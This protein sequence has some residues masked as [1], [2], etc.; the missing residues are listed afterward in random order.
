MISAWATGK[1]LSGI[2][3][4]MVYSEMIPHN[5]GVIFRKEFVDLRD[6]TL[7]DFEKYTGKKVNSQRNADL[8]NGSKIMFRHLEE[9]NNLQNLNLGWFF[10]EQAEELA[11]DSEFFLLWGRLR[12]AVNPSQEFLDLNLPL[13]SG[14]I[15]GNVKGNNWIKT[16][17]K[18]NPKEDFELTEA[19][20][21][22]NADVLPDDFIKNIKRLKELQPERYRRFVLN[23]WEVEAEG[24]AIPYKLIETCTGGELADPILGHEY[25]LGTD[26]AKHQDWTVIIVAD[27]QG[28]QVVYFDRFQRES[29]GLVRGKIVATAK[30]YNNA[31]VIPDSTGVGDPITEDLERAGCRVYRDGDRPGYVFTARSK[32][33]LIEN[34]IVTM[35]NRGIKYPHIPKLIDEMKEF[36]RTESKAGNIQYSAPQGKHDDCVIALA[37]ACWGLA[38]GASCLSMRNILTGERL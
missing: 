13:H 3:R 20:T 9:M 37:L 26:L 11:S 10:I 4:S 24:L 2:L 21:F 38:S 29:W 31:E 1:S 14:F 25:V 12:R 7:I 32:E 23:D 6:S 18:N 35:T 36:E 16:L 17:W 5:L 19:I 34:L 27:K 8:K 33:Q 28:G 22:D 15:V 30:R